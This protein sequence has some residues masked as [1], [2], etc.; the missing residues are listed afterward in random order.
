LIVSVIRLQAYTSGA[1]A[2]IVFS[3]DDGCD[4]GVATGSPFSSD[5]GSHGN[6]FNGVVKGVQLEIAEDAVS[7]GHLVEPEQA[8]RVGMARQ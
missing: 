4:V 8:L 5:D 7:I 2:A 1:T 6:Q 3:A